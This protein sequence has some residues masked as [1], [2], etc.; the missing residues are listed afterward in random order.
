M[1]QQSS[2]ITIL[3][4]TGVAYLIYTACCVLPW[5]KAEPGSEM[6]PGL[7]VGGIAYRSDQR[8][9][10]DEV[11]ARDY[12]QSLAGLDFSCHDVQ[13]LLDIDKLGSDFTQ[14]LN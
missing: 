10:G 14:L 1:D 7:K 11:D 2:K 5:Y 13:M 4:L 12:H 3:S 6:S 9:S 8:R